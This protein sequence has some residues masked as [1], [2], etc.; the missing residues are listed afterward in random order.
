[1]NAQWKAEGQKRRLVARGI[2]A[3]VTIYDSAK[4]TRIAPDSSARA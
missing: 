4:K 3:T 1:M 2:N